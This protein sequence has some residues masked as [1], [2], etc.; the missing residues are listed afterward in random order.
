MVL[1]NILVGQTGVTELRQEVDTLLKQ[2]RPLEALTI[3]ESLVSREDTIEGY[4]RYK[5]R[6]GFLYHSL[7]SIDK[8]RQWYHS[9]LNDSM[10]V[11]SVEDYWLGEWE[12]RGNYKHVSCHNIAASYYKEKDYDKAIEYYK[13]A[14]DTFP[15]YHFSGSDINK[16]KVKISNN[17]AD[18]YSKKGDL[19]QAFSYLLPFFLN[20]VVYSE[21][22]TNKAMRILKEHNLQDQFINLMTKDHKALI[23]KDRIV[24]KL[25]EKEIVLED[26][27]GQNNTE[28]SLEM[29]ALMHW[30]FYLSPLIKEFKEFKEE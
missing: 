11:D 19:T 15:Y 18:V 14:L 16:N 22:A 27:T 2:D 29:T 5:T 21:R 8:A 10:I 23:D 25:G 20:G 12:V 4:A 9:V 24:L 6:I 1:T 3:M 28:T 13:L 17:I 30:E 7:D 26:L